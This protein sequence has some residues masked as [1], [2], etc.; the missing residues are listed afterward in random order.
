MAPFGA[1][2]AIEYGVANRMD[3]ISLHT[4]ALA[5][6]VSVNRWTGPDVALSA[7]TDNPSNMPNRLL[8]SLQLP[9]LNIDA[10]TRVNPTGRNS[11]APSQLLSPD[12][13]W[14]GLYARPFAPITLAEAL[15]KLAAR[16]V[17]YIAVYGGFDAEAAP[18]RIDSAIRA[19]AQAAAQE[20]S[21]I[22]VPAY[23][24]DGAGNIIAGPFEDWVE[25]VVSAGMTPAVDLFED[26]D[27][28]QAVTPAQVL[29][30]G[31]EWVRFKAF[32][33]EGGTSLER[34]Q[35]FVD[36]GIQVIAQSSSRQYD[37]QLLFSAGVRGVMADSAVY[38][39]GGRGES[40][41]LNY[42]KTVV[43]PGLV[44][45]TPIEGSLTALTDDGYGRAD[46]GWARQSTE[47]RYFSAQFGWQGGIGPRLNSQLLGELCPLN[48]PADYRLRVR[49]RVDPT[50]TTVP[51]GFVPAIGLFVASPT[52]RDITTFRDDGNP[53][54]HPWVNG[55]WCSVGIGTVRQGQIRI[56]KYTDGVCEVLD[57]SQSLPSVSY[58]DWIYMSVRI[59]PTTV[60][61]A[62]GHS[63]ISGNIV[64]QVDDN[65]HRGPYAYYA[66][67]SDWASPVTNDGFAHGY[68]AYQNYATNSPMYEEP[69]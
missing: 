27:G 37:T 60:T 64:T 4:Y 26:V 42:R 10:G 33:E 12:G 38:A 48:R 43:I 21:I 13:G 58:G 6:G 24:D 11:G 50:Q 52:D 54:A 61:C 46:A 18:I 36:A 22:S 2:Y 44:T 29:A 51:S 30:S 63:T 62:I 56:A 23:V 45:R 66:W 40:G 59:T 1:P 14:F 5:D 20:W 17:A 25:N 9:S 28:D 57:D 69:V 41:D 65:D 32:E 53:D 16:S 68:S 8:S 31:A 34:I 7:Y 39:R 55:Y 3:F 35:E 15:H 49:F 47:G 67:E 19:V